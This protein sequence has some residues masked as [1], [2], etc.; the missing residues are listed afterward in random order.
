MA[1]LSC[2]EIE[3]ERYDVITAWGS[4]HHISN[5]RH[6]FQQ[7]NRALKPHGTFLI[8]DDIDWARMN[9][10]WLGLAYL[11]IPGHEPIGQR[12]RKL[13][14]RFTHGEAVI[15]SK[16]ERQRLPRDTGEDSP[17]E[18]VHGVDI[19]DL[20]REFFHVHR[21]DTSVAFSLPMFLQMAKGPDC[22]TRQHRHRVLRTLKTVE[23]GLIRVG[24]AKGSMAVMKATK[25]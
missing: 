20:V 10:I 18:M 15:L 3:P 9:H 2:L 5:L 21:L 6:L 8:Y 16:A 24:L 19:I 1:D 12:L 7:V 14:R 22:W 25:Q 11:L 4:L 13:W 17:F 23:D